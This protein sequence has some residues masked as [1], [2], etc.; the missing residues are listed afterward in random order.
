MNYRIQS[1]KEKLMKVLLVGFLIASS[2]FIVKALEPTSIKNTAELTQAIEEANDGDELG[3]DPSF[4]S[5]NFTI[6]TNKNLTIKGNNA[7]WTK[8]QLI[9]SGSGNF[10]LSDIIFDGE[11][12]ATSKYKLVVDRT[13]GTI[14]LKTITFKNAKNGS[15]HVNTNSVINIDDSLFTDAIGINLAPAITL[16]ANANVNINNTTIK[17]NKGTGGGWET[18]AISSKNFTGNLVIKNTLF[19]NNIN[20]TYNTGVV[21]G[22]GGAIYINGLYGK[23]LI[24]QSVFKGN[25]TNGGNG[26]KAATYDGGAINLFNMRPGASFNVDQTTFEDNVA[27]DDGGAILIQTVGPGTGQTIEDIKITNSTFY[28]NKAYGIATAEYAGGAIQIFID[29][30]FTGKTYTDVHLKGNTFVNNSVGGTLNGV[31][32]TDGTPAGA[33]LG[34]SP[35]NSLY[36]K[37]YVYMENNLFAN[38]YLEKG[39]VKTYNDASNGVNVSLKNYIKTNI[40]NIVDDNVSADS[41]T[42]TK[43]LLGV[44]VPKLQKNYTGITAGVEKTPIPTIPIKPSGAADNSS[45]TALTSKDQRGFD[46][47]KD[48]GA[49]EMSWINYDANGGEFLLEDLASYDG[50][51]YYEKKTITENEITKEFYDSFYDISYVNAASKVLQTVDKSTSAKK[52]RTGSNKSL[53][54]K[55]DGYVFLGWSTT[56]YTDQDI[57]DGTAIPDFVSG[58]SI[59][60]EAENKTLY[61]VW[62]LKYTVTYTDGVDGVDVFEDD[63]HNEL[64]FGAN[65]PAF[66]GGEPT[67]EGYTFAGWTPTVAPTVTEN[68]T[69]TATWTPK[70]YTVTYTDGVDGVDVFEDDVHNELSFGA[71]TPAFV[72][73]EPTREGYTFAGWTPAVADTVTESV[74]YTATWTIKEY[75]VTYTDGVADEVVFED[76][77]HTVNHFEST[78]AFVGG[79]PTR[80]G[81]TFVG[82]TPAVAGTVTETI[83]Y[84]AIWTQD[85]IPVIPEEPKDP[86]I[87]E[88]PKEPELPG[89]G[90]DTNLSGLGFLLIGFLVI[91]IGSLEKKMKDNYK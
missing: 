52:T 68:V 64:S 7:N 14:S 75:T 25:E 83:T 29:V 5:D 78:P 60:F 84:T 3:L 82:W 20:M 55:R 10:T 66:V 42:T 70:E 19:E 43:H 88:E 12:D 47:F 21:G 74:T 50:T 62:T 81:Y 91:V 44:D 53:E 79:I 41:T 31:D 59:N 1:I 40:N 86:V 45:S 76:D 72:G 39:G 35:T 77:V 71:N 57:E 30:G 89:T 61:A 24:S 8:G 54:I 6:S 26:E 67:R 4:E 16:V 48:A 38:N 87:P 37:I 56:K 90:I 33:V 85:E 17:N 46:R 27:Y 51:H 15:L 49:T 18:G 34:L 22:G 69:Y 11:N 2:S 65:T 63:V 36:S 13:G 23:V 32:I 73:G 28:N 9:L 80:E 58:D